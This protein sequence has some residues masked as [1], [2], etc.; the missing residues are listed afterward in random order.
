MRNT[1]LHL[2]LVGIFLAIGQYSNVSAQPTNWLMPKTLVTNIIPANLFLTD[3]G[4]LFWYGSSK[5][6]VIHLKDI[7][8]AESSPESRP[9]DSDPEG[10]WGAPS[11]GFQLSLRFAKQEFTNGEQI[12]ATM[13]LRN[14]TNV[15]EKFD[16]LYVAGRPSPINLLVF[17]EQE[18]LRLEGDDG[19]IN[20]IS[21]T[22]VTIYPQ[23]QLK[24]SVKVNDYYN[25]SRGGKF[26]VKAS[27][28]RQNEI[29]S[30]KVP[31]EIR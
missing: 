10:N 16:R 5:R 17:S 19:E 23:T 11:N 22:E 26:F 24:F 14:I 13:L 1:I 4:K 30:Q 9:A 12:V 3:D 29:A 28:G 2:S 15:P 31:I 21:A 27:Y 7:A 25:L 20:V 6:R 8:A 18:Q